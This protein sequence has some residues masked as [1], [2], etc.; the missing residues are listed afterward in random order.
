MISTPEQALR[1][2]PWT[3]LVRL[4]LRIESAVSAERTIERVYFNIAWLY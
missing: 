4:E 2:E 1:N 3:G